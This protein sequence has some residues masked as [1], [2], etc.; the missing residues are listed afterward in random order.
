MWANL[1]ARSSRPGAT[2]AS[3]AIARQARPDLYNNVPSAAL[4]QKTLV[5]S[6]LESQS[7]GFYFPRNNWFPWRSRLA[8]QRKAAMAKKRN[9]LPRVRDPNERPIRVNKEDGNQLAFRA[10]EVRLGMK[11]LLDYCR[12]VRGKQLQDGIDWVESLAR[13]KSEPLL[14]MMKAALAECAEKHKWDPARI[15]IFDAQPQRGKYVR[16]LRKHARANF[17]IVRRPR[18][19]FMIRLRQYPLEEYFHKVYIYNKVP[20]SLASDMR[21]ALH[22]SR[23]N[24]QM[25]K[26]WAPYLC[27]NS[28]LHHRRNL[29]WRDATRQFDYYEQRR[30]WIQR[31]Q[32]NILRGSAES[33]EAR[34]LAPLAA[35]E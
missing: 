19:Y 14:K 8:H 3:V 31:Y 5:R 34:G 9:I 20:R 28:R 33:R 23:V 32:T 27:A 13:M 26:E 16:E 15:Y 25:Q 11:R 29:K 7:R 4:P 1:A 18:N 22:Q 2:S 6:S 21:L 17:G 10:K 12:L 24:P 35:E 30:E